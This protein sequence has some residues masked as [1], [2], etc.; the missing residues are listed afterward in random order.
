MSIF[1]DIGKAVGI[2]VKPD[3]TSSEIFGPLPGIAQGIARVVGG[4]PSG[5]SASINPYS[6]TVSQQ[7]PTK[8]PTIKTFGL[9]K[10]T[11]GPPY[12]NVLEQFASYNSIWTLCCLEPNQF[13]NPDSYRGKPGAL[14]N[15]VISS[16]GRYDEQ[17]VKTVNG[18]PEFFIDN[19][20]FVTR[21]AGQDAG[22]TNVTGLTFE[23]Y[24]PYSM[25]LFYQ[26]LQ[27]A[28]IDA[29]YPQYVGETPFLLK[30]EFVGFDDKGRIFASKESL[31]KYF[32]IKITDSEMKVDEG[33]SRYKVTAVP[34]HHMGYHDGANIYAPD[35]T[36]TGNTV[37]EVLSSG[38]SSLMNALNKAQF[39]LVDA[40]LAD[41]PDLYE[42]VFPVDWQDRVGLEGGATPDTLRAIVDLNAGK[43]IKAGS[44]ADFETLEYGQGP[45]GFSSMGFSSTSGGNYLFK[46]AADVVDPI[47]GRILKDSMSIDPNRRTFTFGKMS[48]ITNIIK[49]I[50]LASEYCAKNL[51]PEAIDPVTGLVNWFRVDVQIDLLEFDKIRNQRA[52]KYIYRV[53]P[54]QV[55]SEYLKNPTSA[56]PTQG[57]EAICAKRYNYIYSGLNNDIL[58]LDLIFNGMFTTG[59]LPRPPQK[60]ASIQNTDNQSAAETKRLQAQAQSGNA[61][62]AAASESG[63][64]SVK[65]NYK[66]STGTF[67]GEKNVQQVIADAFQ[68]AFQNGNKDMMQVKMEIIGD[69][70]Y[71]S[72]AGICSKYLGEYGPN[73]QITADGT[74]NWQGSEIFVYVTFRNPIEPNLG[75]TG[76]GGLFNFPKGQWVSPYSGLYRVIAVE[77]KWSNGVYTQTLDMNRIVNQSVD[78]AGRAEIER[79]NQWLYE[80]K[81]APPQTG[82]VDTTVYGGDEGE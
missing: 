68:N 71:L 27:A 53:V 33:G 44:S 60:H 35:L 51:K 17:R 9:E 80:T 54:F 43:P 49:L 11:S 37:L 70:F 18:S 13:N 4:L 16:A 81:E 3:G 61:P 42:I 26:S 40:N 2:S 23:V 62:E 31:A 74:M 63:T 15:V 50:V 48:L 47:T 22:W 73:Q 14:K 34:L 52:K 21:L 39:E 59:A 82:P 8:T 76:Q 25:G 41:K 38:K 72:D 20:N 57:R 64:P 32:T 12:P 66:I 24:E 78:F 28:A 69:P 19:V 75:T 45:I 1:R 5:N 65:P 29:G 67:S 79:Q 58:K 56:T 36:I 6:V 77:N 7:D 46:D 30:L 55:S 10:I